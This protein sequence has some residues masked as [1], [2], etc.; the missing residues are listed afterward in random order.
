MQAARNEMTNG[1]SEIANARKDLKTAYNDL[2]ET[3]S[4]TKEVRDAISGMF[5]EAE[6]NY[7]A[8]IDE[9]ADTIQ[10]TYQQT[11][12]TGFKDMASSLRSAP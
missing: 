1:R 7:L 5:D 9:E 12:N 2:N 8:T 4:Q 3:I 6:A 10:A 11:L